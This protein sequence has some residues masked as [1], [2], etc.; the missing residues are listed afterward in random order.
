VDFLI[1]VSVSKDFYRNRLNALS[2]MD[3]HFIAS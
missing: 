3:L 2:H 1:G